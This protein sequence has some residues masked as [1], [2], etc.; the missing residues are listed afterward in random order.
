MKLCKSIDV[1]TFE[2]LTVS[3]VTAKFNWIVKLDIIMKLT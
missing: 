3:S 1:Q 2:S